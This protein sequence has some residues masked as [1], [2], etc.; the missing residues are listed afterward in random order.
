MGRGQGRAWVE[1]SGTNPGSCFDDL[2]L[3][4]WIN[5]SMLHACVMDAAYS[6]WSC[7]DR[8]S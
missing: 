3:G 4:I 2:L 5:M 1:E 6:I 7:L 8:L